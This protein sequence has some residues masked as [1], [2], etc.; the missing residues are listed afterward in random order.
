MRATS[1][2]SAHLAGFGAHG[3]SIGDAVAIALI[4]GL[5]LLGVLV[6]LI[7]TFTEPSPDRRSGADGDSGPGGGGRGPGGGGPD[8]P[9]PMGD[10]PVW[11]SEFER[12]FADYVTSTI[13][14]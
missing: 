1:V 8:G 7:L 4:V 10:A 13:R 11:W 6:T 2:H 5:C 3:A 14:A 9:Q 12:Q